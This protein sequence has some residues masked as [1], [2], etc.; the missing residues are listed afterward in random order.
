[1]CFDLNEGSSCSL[2]GSDLPQQ[3]PQNPTVKPAAQQRAAPNP[4]G[5]EDGCKV[6]L[7][8]VEAQ[9]P[10][11]LPGSVESVGSPRCQ[12]TAEQPQ[13]GPDGCWAWRFTGHYAEQTHL[14]LAPLLMA[15]FWCLLLT[16]GWCLTLT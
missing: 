15:V 6:L 16:W 12:L 10:G 1:M 11:G 7:L 4:A 13:L 8:Q 2:L 3:I 9:V 14:L 5:E